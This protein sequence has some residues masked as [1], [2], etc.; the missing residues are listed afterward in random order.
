MMFRW[1]PWL[2]GVSWLGGLAGLLLCVLF[3]VW[4]VRLATGAHHHEPPRWTPGGPVAPGGPIAPAAPHQSPQEILRARFARGEI[5]EAEYVR[6]KDLL[7][8]DK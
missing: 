4:I 7:G 5:A 6:M 3:V 8:P 2:M 1:D